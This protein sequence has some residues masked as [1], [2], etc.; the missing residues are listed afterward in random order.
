MH[1]KSKVRLSMIYIYKYIGIILIPLIKL[2]ILIRIKQSKEVAYRHKERFGITLHSKPTKKLIWIHAA[3]VG[4]FKSADVLINNLHK[5]YI[6]LITTTTVSAAE[7]A[8]A[9]YKDKIIHQFA[10]LDVDLWIKRFLQYW[11]PSLVIWIESDIWP[12]TM[13]ILKKFKINAILVNVRM[14]PQ[15]FNKWK[16]FSFFYKQTLGC[17]SEIF[18]QSQID[19][20]RIMSLIKREV[21]FIGNLKLASLKK[22]LLQNNNSNLT[23][24]NKSLNLMMVSS[25]E[26][27][28]VK[29]LPMIKKLLVNNSNMRVIL[30]PRHPERSTKIQSLCNSLQIPSRLEDNNS[31]NTQEIVIVNSFGHLPS[32]FKSSD[33]V[34]LGGSLISKGGH[35]PLEPAVHNCALITGPFIYN[36]QNTYEDMFIN[37]A[38]LKIQTVDDLEIKIQDLISNGNLMKKMKMNAYK[39]AQKEFFNTQVLLNSIEKQIKKAS[40]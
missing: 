3:S 18:A 38:C 6:V 30:A 36:W 28:E 26:G 4:E 33:I 2:N 31:S 32:Y 19:Q 37:E 15:S 1:S 8:M 29:L 27:E 9:H 11:N 23:F 20:K 39:F 25:H 24:N 16:K 7:Y 17:F 14:S 35:N 21:K 40:C 34:F 5:K 22:T 10:P 12:I 13:H